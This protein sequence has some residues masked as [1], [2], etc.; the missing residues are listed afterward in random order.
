[1]NPAFLENR[2]VQFIRRGESNVVYAGIEGA[3]MRSDDAGASYDFVLHYEGDA[4]KY[5][6]IT[7]ILFPSQRFSPAAS[8]RRTAGRSCRC[9]PTTASRGPI[10]RICCRVQATSHGR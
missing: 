2:N 9:R 5:P 8:I 3:L 4:A 1:M 7:H 6:Y 10:S